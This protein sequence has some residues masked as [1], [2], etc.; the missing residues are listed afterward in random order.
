MKKKYLSIIILMALLVNVYSQNTITD[1]VWMLKQVENDG[2]TE[3]VY[4]TLKFKTDG[5][6]QMQGRVFGR[7]SHNKK[8][9]SITIESRMVEEF[10]NVWVIKKQLKNELVL[11]SGKTTMYF[12]EYDIESITAKNKK[13]QLVG[14]WK[15]EA[16]DNEQETK[17]IKFELPNNVLI[18]S[19]NERNNSV[20]PGEWYSINNKELVIK[21]RDY[22]FRGTNKIK[23]ISENKFTLQNSDNKIAAI[24]VEPNAKNREVIKFT[25]NNNSEQEEVTEV[26]DENGEYN[27][28]DTQ[29]ESWTYVEPKI[30]YL[31]KLMSITYKKSVLIK[32]LDIFTE[33]QEKININFDDEKSKLNFNDALN[34]LTTDYIDNSNIFYPL[35]NTNNYTKL[36]DEEITVPAGTFKCNVYR[37]EYNYGDVITRLYMIA[38]KPGVYA[39]IIILEKKFDK[40]NYT[41]FELTNISSKYK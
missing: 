25:D 30:E 8:E 35:K 28:E 38:D 19:I 41:M 1:R 17:Y 40:E 9:N 33:Q 4:Q 26:S 5:Y 3:A 31:K 6:V 15:L 21:S 13:T 39:K 36:K 22:S 34:S 14:I 7:W 20:E 32:E 37:A 11:E 2:N 10:A 16:N 18:V 24:K 23:S 29:E 27:N 12:S